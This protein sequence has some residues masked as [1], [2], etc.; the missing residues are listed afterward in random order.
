MSTLTAT[1]LNDHLAGSTI[2][3]EL[4]RRSASSNRGSL[5]GQALSE[6]CEQIAQDRQMLES[7]MQRLGVR[8][9]RV[10]LT[11]AWCGEKL[12]RAKPNGRLLSYSPL[13]RLEEL[14]GLAIGVHGKLMLWEALE[15]GNTDGRLADLDFENLRARALEQQRALEGLRR[16][17]VAQALA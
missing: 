13:S 17:A 6:L 5:Y 8:K 16:E 15:H 10:K 4:C 1:Y 7:I 11:L 3:L 9:D 12:G 14:E 2:A